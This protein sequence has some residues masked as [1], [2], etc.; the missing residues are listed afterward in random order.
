ML[1]L[2]RWILATELSFEVYVRK[3]DQQGI[4]K[5]RGGSHQADKCVKYSGNYLENR[6]ESQNHW[7][8]CAARDLKDLPVPTLHGQ[9]GNIFT[10]FQ[11]LHDDNILFSRL[12]FHLVTKSRKVPAVGN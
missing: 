6:K 3:G 7:L 8:V 5:Y 12:L 10:I 1:S 2:E 4:R 9:K 11:L